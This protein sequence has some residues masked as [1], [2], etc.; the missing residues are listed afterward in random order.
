MSS[1]CWKSDLYTGYREELFSSDNGL[2]GR[3]YRRAL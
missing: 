1:K 3:G 2:T